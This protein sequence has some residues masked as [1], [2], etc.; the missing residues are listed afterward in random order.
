MIFNVRQAVTVTA[1]FVTLPSMTALAEKAE[2]VTVN[3]G[4]VIGVIPA[5]HGVNSGP[6]L[7]DHTDE[8]PWTPPCANHNSHDFTTQFAEVGI[9]QSRSHDQG[10]FDINVIWKPWPEFKMEDLEDP[11]NFDWEISDDFAAAVV[12][13]GGQLYPMVGVSQSSCNSATPEQINDLRTPPDPEV[14]GEIVKRVLMHYTEGWEDGFFYDIEQV[15]IW[16]E[17]NVH[18]FWNGT[19][20]DYHDLYVA[21]HEAIHGHFG[22]EIACVLHLGRDVFSQGVI[23]AFDPATEPI[24][25]VAN[26]YYS[27]RPITFINGLLFK[28]DRATELLNNQGYP[29]DEIPIFISEWNRD[30]WG[31]SV[32]VASFA[33][34]ALTYFVGLHPDNVSPFTGE[35]HNVVMGHHYSSEG[36]F[37]DDETGE[38][39]NM[40][41]LWRVFGERL[42]AQTPNLL[43]NA[44]A[45]FSD[46]KSGTDFCVLPGRSEDRGLIHVLISDYTN[47]DEEPLPAHPGEDYP[48]KVTVTDLPWG[49]EAFTWERWRHDTDNQLRLADFGSAEGLT[50]W[51][52]NGTGTR[53]TMELFVL[54]AVEA[55]GPEDEPEPA[56][57]SCSCSSSP[58][59][60][61]PLGA[62]LVLGGVLVRRRRGTSLR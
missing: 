56:P 46:E 50:E 58:S 2:E 13:A 57:E 39:L 38:D 3:A 6:L 26:H 12:E 25:A 36:N 48:L 49:T 30:T 42:V 8:P 37:W 33:G 52:Y 41:V 18:Y 47:T 11:S 29:G 51:N 45:W 24:D 23:D 19:S 32:T 44:G 54:N 40:G 60:M 59:G 22:D 21:A 20:Q 10:P 14:Y 34:C 1:L 5:I 31:N 55:P 35:S 4:E 62:I 15:A 53:S 61:A 17:P 43:A 7:N 28:E 16:T 27:T 9:P